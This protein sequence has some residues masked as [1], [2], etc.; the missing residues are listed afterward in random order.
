MVAPEIC[1]A[2]EPSDGLEPSTLLTME[3]SPRCYV[4]R[5]ER[6]V[7]R[8]PCNSGDFS[9]C[10]TPS[11]KNP[12]PPR[13]GSNLSPKPSPKRAAGRGARPRL[14]TLREGKAWLFFVVLSAG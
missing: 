9:A 10:C 2:L 6:L 14:A 3:V 7:D 13:K 1:N 11:S 12:E 5:E 8:F 4:V